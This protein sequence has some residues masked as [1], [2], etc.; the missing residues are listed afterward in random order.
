MYTKDDVAKLLADIAELKLDPPLEVG[1][2]LSFGLEVD[3]FDP[4]SGQ[5]LTACRPQR[6]DIGETEIRLTAA[7]VGSA[8]AGM[9]LAKLH[10]DRALGITN[11][12]PQEAAAALAAAA[13]AAADDAQKAQEA[14][15]AAP[16]NEALAKAAADAKVR[17][18]TSAA[19]AKN[20]QVNAEAAK[21]REA[22]KGK[23]QPA[24]VAA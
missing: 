15:A 18:D 5:I 1:Q 21:A 6:T 10:S 14:S 16:G 2:A 11:I 3:L 23:P 17:A 24:K 13:K 4:V 9:R 8:V 20:A 12:D 19:I 22:E 7:Q